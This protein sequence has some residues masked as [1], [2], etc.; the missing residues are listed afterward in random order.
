M[1]PRETLWSGPDELVVNRDDGLR[2]HRK[3]EPGICV[4][5]GENRGVDANDFAVHIDQRATG[6]AG[7]D[8]GVRLDE[9][10]ELAL[11]NDICGRLA[12]TIPAVTVSCRPNGLPMA[13][14]Q[15]PTCMLSELPSLRGRQRFARLQL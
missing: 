15:S 11:G 14:T 12:E 4:G 5:F 13:R 6:V 3:T 1:E 7:I 9:R 8:R 2:R 10:L